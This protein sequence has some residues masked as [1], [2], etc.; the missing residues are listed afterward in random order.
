MLKPSNNYSYHKRATKLE[1]L[2][3]LPSHYLCVVGAIYTGKYLSCDKQT[4]G[5]QG[6]HPD[7][8]IIHYKKEG[9]GF[10]RDCICADGYTYFFFCNLVVLKIFIDLDMSPLH[11]QVHA[12]CE[13]LPA[14]N[15]VLA[16][17]NIYMSAK[18]CR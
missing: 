16:M 1:V 10:Q 9:D 6:R 15:C 2:H 11:A 18:L 12:L 17:D 13:Q 8:L 14:K 7:I 4:I 5:S 3:I